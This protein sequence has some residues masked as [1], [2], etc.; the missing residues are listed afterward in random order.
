[1]AKLDDLRKE[2]SVKQDSVVG[3]ELLDYCIAWL[4]NHIRVT[5]VRVLLACEL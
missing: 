3:K 1:M 2:L 4:T 5:D